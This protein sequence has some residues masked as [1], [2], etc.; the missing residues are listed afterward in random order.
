MTDKKTKPP[1]DALVDAIIADLKDQHM[2]PDARETELLER[3][4]ACA[5]RIAELGE[6]CGQNRFDLRR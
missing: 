1:G 3:A 5:D 4:R 6:G 2:M